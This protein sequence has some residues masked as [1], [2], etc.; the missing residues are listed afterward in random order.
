MGL[1]FCNT[2]ARH[3]LYEGQIQQ[4]STLLSNYAIELLRQVSNMQPLTHERAALNQSL[5]NR[6]KHLFAQCFNSASGGAEN[7]ANDDDYDKTNL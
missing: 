3:L 7:D 6:L 2:L 1:L 4:S 5:I